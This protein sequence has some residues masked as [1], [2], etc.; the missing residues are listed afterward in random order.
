MNINQAQRVK[1]SL[2]TFFYKV[3]YNIGLT[4]VID[5]EQYDVFA[6]NIE[7]ALNNQILYYAKFEKVND[8]IGVKKAVRELTDTELLKNLDTMWVP[9]TDLIE[10]DEMLLYFLWLADRGGQQAVNKLGSS[11]AFQLTNKALLNEIRRHMNDSIAMIDTTTKG[12]IARTVEQGLRDNETIL[13][14]AKLL[15]DESIRISKLRSDRIAEYEAAYI[16]GEMATEVYNRS[17]VEFHAWVTSRDERVCD[18][19]IK[20]EQAG[21]VRVGT[22]FPNG[23]IHTPAHLLCRCFTMPVVTNTTIDIWMG[24]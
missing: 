18:I 8:I 19:C 9:L 5:S 20:N 10:T 15:R 6:K 13:E 11:E 3:R 12:W 16:L 7:T 1:R 21:E 2:E 17:G 23:V 24:N 4:T 22:P 14:I